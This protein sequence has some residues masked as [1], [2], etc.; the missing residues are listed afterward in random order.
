[1]KFLFK[2]LFGWAEISDA[3]NA[4]VCKAIRIHVAAHPVC[5]WC[6]NRDLGELTAHHLVPINVAHE[7][8]LVES[9][10]VTLC[11]ERDG[12]RS[13]CHLIVGHLGNWK[14][15]NRKLPQQLAL[16]AEVKS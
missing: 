8:A 9:N 5:A 6:G 12:H 7:L 11:Q 15:I 2:K 4:A 16:L 3:E 13:A 14:N 1:M 10:L